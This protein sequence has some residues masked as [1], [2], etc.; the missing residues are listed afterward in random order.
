MA[1]V[2]S[3][4]STYF[5][6][7]SAVSRSPSSKPSIYLPKSL[8]LHRSILPNSPILS[9]LRSAFPQSSRTPPTTSPS[10]SRKLDSLLLLCTSVALSCSFFLAD[11]HSASA[12]VV[13]SPK[14]LQSD[15]LATVR[16]FQENTPS[17]VYITNLAAK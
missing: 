5:H 6:S 13:T 9:L 3:L 15:E 16:L 11:V 10:A 12:F 8:H 2:C 1:S 17:V 7:T 4:S 14:K